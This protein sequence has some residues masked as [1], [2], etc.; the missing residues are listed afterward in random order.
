MTLQIEADLLG[1]QQ[2]KGGVLATQR[3]IFIDEQGTPLVE[4]LWSNF[5]IGG[6]IAEAVGTPTPD[7]TFPEGAR[8]H[9]VGSRT[10]TV[11]RDQQYRFAGVSNDHAPHAM[12]LAAARREGYPAKILQGMCTFALTNAALVDLVADGNPHRFR[13]MAGR[14]SAPV[15]AGRDFVVDAYDAGT[16]PNGL[17]SLAF[18]AIQD[19]VVVIK[20]GRVE[21]T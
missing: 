21:L 15:L 9:P 6:T 18:E 13:R 10:V 2:T 3:F 4:H 20:H 11:E 14:F 19:G 1:A 8:Q 7:H 16:L 17:R 5:H 12:T